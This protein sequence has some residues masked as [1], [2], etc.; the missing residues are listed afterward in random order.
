[1]EAQALAE[2][3]GVPTEE[4]FE[5][6]GF[7]P[8]PAGRRG[9][10]ASV[11]GSMTYAIFRQAAQPQ[12]AMRVLE[13]AVAPA[14]LARLAQATGRVPAR[15]SAV[16]LAAPDLPFLSETAEILARAVTRPTIP[17]YPR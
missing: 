16:D 2:A 7:L 13:S 5:H 17:L 9:R 1:Y 12:L 6:V 14:A 3:F 8:V 11:A 10:Q 4:L 15:R